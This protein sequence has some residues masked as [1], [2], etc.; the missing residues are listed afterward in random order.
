MEILKFLQ[1][2]SWYVFAGLGFVGITL[3]IVYKGGK[4]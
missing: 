3:L 4:R 1:G 2:F